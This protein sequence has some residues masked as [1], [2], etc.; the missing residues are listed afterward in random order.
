[1]N[2]AGCNPNSPADAAPSVTN[3]VIDSGAVRQETGPVPTDSNAPTGNDR[4]RH[5]CVGSAGCRWCARENQ[6]AL[7]RARGHSL[8]G[9][10][11]SG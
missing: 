1:M 5:G 6:Y 3:P 9:V 7:E 4:D 11:P 8:Q 10:Y 2:L